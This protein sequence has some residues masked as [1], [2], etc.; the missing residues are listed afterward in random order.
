MK[1]ILLIFSAL[2]CLLVP[3]VFPQESASG[4]HYVIVTGKPLIPAE[5]DAADIL[6]QY[7]KQMLPHASFQI[8]A[9]DAMPAK[10]STQ[11]KKQA[12]TLIELLVVI[13][14][15]AILASMLL[16]ALSQARATAKQVSCINNIKQIGIAF[17]QVP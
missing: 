14:I 10:R 7:L 16:P 1:K 3:A 2:L 13:A 11:I 4:E 9:E 15:I 8:A 17:T 6:L 12:F 5:K